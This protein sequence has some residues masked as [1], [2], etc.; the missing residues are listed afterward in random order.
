MWPTRGR[1]VPTR[2]SESRPLPARGMHLGCR[3][4]AGW[5]V[6]GAARRRN[7]CKS[8]VGVPG[9]EPGTSSLSGRLHSLPR[10]AQGDLGSH[11]F[12]STRLR[13]HDEPGP[14]SPS[15]RMRLTRRLGHAEATAQYLATKSRDSPTCTE[16]C[17]S[18]TSRT[19]WSELAPM[20]S[21]P[22]RRGAKCCVRMSCSPRATIARRR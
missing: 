12:A 7:P 8:L 11:R 6:G 15:V 13:A 17:A 2:S 4:V 14:A 3:M 22:R 19:R 20:I 10:S 21:T 1:F 5:D 16:G 9:F 18:S